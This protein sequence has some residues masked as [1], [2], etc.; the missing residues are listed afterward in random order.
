VPHNYRPS[1]KSSKS[2]LRRLK[3]Q[4]NINKTQPISLIIS[5]FG[6]K[7]HILFKFMSA[8]YKEIVQSLIMLLYDD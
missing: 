3:H 5:E 2:F 6:F 1:F 8:L 4:K 7:A